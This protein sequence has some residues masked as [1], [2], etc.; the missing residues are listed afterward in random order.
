MAKTPIII[1]TAV[2]G[3][4]FLMEIIGL[5]TPH[6]MVIKAF[7]LH[8]GVFQICVTNECVTFIGYLGFSIHYLGFVVCQC[9]GCT[10]MLISTISGIV[11][12]TSSKRPEKII[13]KKLA[14]LCFSSAF[15][16]LVSV[17]WFALAFYNNIGTLYSLYTSAIVTLGYSF[18]LS[19]VSGIGMLV[20][21]ISSCVIA[22]N[23][24]APPIVAQAPHAT[25][26]QPMIIMATS[27]QQFINQQPITGQSQTQ[28]NGQQP[29]G[30]QPSGYPQGYL[31]TQSAD[32]ANM[33]AVQHTDHP[34]YAPPV[35]PPGGQPIYVPPPIYGG[36]PSAIGD[37]G[38]CAPN[39]A[40]PAQMN[41]KPS[42]Y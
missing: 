27:N 22:Q 1:A 15:F 32:P 5:A 12:A 28:I 21:G 23:M 3:V 4:M 30:P 25:G 29:I 42:S 13:I 10:L 17:T 7:G 26:Q 31:A 37:Y 24:P 20:I 11:G 41:E 40:L 14:S 9:L 36:Q 2:I 34:G 19:L 33:A 35:A 39:P 18:V 16:I 38:P 8:V 6:W